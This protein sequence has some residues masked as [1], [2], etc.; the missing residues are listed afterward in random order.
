MAGWWSGGGDGG[1]GVS[2]PSSAH[3][4][5]LEASVTR[6]TRTGDGALTPPLSA[7]HDAATPPHNSCA[8]AHTRAC[9][10]W[11][12]FENVCHAPPSWQ[13]LDSATWLSRMMTSRVTRMGTRSSITFHVQQ[14]QEQGS[15]RRG[16]SNARQVSGIADT[17]PVCARGSR[18]VT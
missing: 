4:A 5:R 18:G 14:E 1:G 6:G 7:T 8:A 2:A 10:C 12:G 3:A 15:R 16:G 17:H 9:A 13:K 11:P